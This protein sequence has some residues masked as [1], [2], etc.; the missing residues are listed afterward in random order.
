VN[1]L[2]RIINHLVYMPRTTNLFWKCGRYTLIAFLV[3][4]VLS[5]IMP[6]LTII[7]NTK[8]IN[9]LAYEDIKPSLIQKIIIL[10]MVYV[11][12]VLLERIL[13]PASQMLQGIFTDRFTAE[14]NL[15]LMNKANSFIGIR[16][17]E[18]PTLKDL[19]QYV[20]NEAS[21]RP[22]NLIA[23]G[24]NVIRY[25]VIVVSMFILLF[26]L[27]PFIV[28]LILLTSIPQ[29]F[30]EY[31]FSRVTMDL[32][33]AQSPDWR[34]VLYYQNVVLG[35]S[36]AKELRLWGI[37]DYF[38]QLYKSTF[39]R[40]HGD[41]TKIRMNRLRTTVIYSLF[42]GIGMSAAFIYIMWL[43]TQHKLLIGEVTLFIQAI[44]LVQVNLITVFGSSA[45]FIE[46]MVWFKKLF[47][48]LDIKDE[49][50]AIGTKSVSLPTKK[51]GKRISL[52]GVGFSYPNSVNMVLKDITVDIEPGEFVA[53]VGENGAGKTS[54]VKLLTQCMTQQKARSISMGPTSGI[55]LPKV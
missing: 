39:N 38:V 14:I 37:G 7:I 36:F 33:M 46:S 12:I 28:L 26:D 13:N 4:S 6:A 25:G 22:M 8:I 32:S 42:G 9:I 16:P 1:F 3:V 17:F 45:L 54:L 20:Q 34:K 50:V 2:K 51:T 21:W 11:L 52:Q 24:S 30:A 5:A 44:I 23:F 27:S 53:I 55:T 48:V 41:L 40:I 43:T 18:D 15:Q 29:L 49:M 47:G 19:I 35:E 31:R 10:G